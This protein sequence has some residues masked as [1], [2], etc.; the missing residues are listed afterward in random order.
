MK[1]WNKNN[2]KKNNKK[3]STNNN[4]KKYKKRNKK[5]KIN[6]LIN[7]KY[8]K[9]Q[10]EKEKEKEKDLENFQTID[11]KDINSKN[12]SENSLDTIIKDLSESINLEVDSENS[13][14]SISFQNKEEIEKSSLMWITP[15]IK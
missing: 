1:K 12:V 3:S 2:S 10:N 4:K 9:E 13:N 11:S 7:I 5:I 15:Q 6:E 8:I 14:A